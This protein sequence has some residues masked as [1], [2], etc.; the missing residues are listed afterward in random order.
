MK[1]FTNSGVLAAMALGIG[2]AVG[3]ALRQAPAARAE[4]E[5]AGGASPRYTVVDTEITNLLVTDNQTNTIYFYTVDKDKEPGSELKLR[6][7][8]DLNQVGK[9]VLTPKRA[10]RD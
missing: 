8:L 7:S 9:P 6:G 2:L 10:D 1:N 4:A 5:K 3:L